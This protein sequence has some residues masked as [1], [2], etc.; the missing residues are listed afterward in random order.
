M[1]AKV[2]NKRLTYLIAVLIGL[3]LIC[4]GDNVYRYL[5]SHKK[6]VTYLSTFENS[7]E[8]VVE[9]KPTEEQKNEETVQEKEY[10]SL[11]DID[12]S[13]FTFKDE[14][15]TLERNEGRSK[16]V[17]IVGKIST[18]EFDDYL[19][20]YRGYSI[21]YGTATK[22]DY[23][24]LTESSF[25]IRNC[26]NTSYPCYAIMY[27]FSQNGNGYLSSVADAKVD[28][29]GNICS[30]GNP[31]FMTYDKKYI[32]ESYYYDEGRGY[33]ITYDQAVKYGVIEDK[34]GYSFS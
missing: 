27:L 7:E 22:P 4:I 30:Y 19:I 26:D 21:S 9:I 23:I 11:S 2:I 17:N 28:R 16:V 13:I 20:K 32:F 6:E 18:Q 3:L 15:L 29:N 25:Y 8:V 14:T 1:N 12:V 33:I 34:K 10:K 5:K 31:Y 24:V